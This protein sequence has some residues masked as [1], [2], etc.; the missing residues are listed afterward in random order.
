[1]ATRETWVLVNGVLVPVEQ[2]TDENDYKRLTIGFQMP[3]ER[4]DEEKTT[5]A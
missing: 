3:R 5:T 4:K 2:K 1:M